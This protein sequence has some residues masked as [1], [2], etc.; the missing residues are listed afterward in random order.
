MAKKEAEQ[1]KIVARADAEKAKQDALTAIEQGKAVV[2]KAQAE[3]NEK[4]IRQVVKAQADF[5]AAQ[6]QKKQAQEV[7]QAKVLEGEA[8]ARVARLKVSAGLTPLERAEIDMKTK[9]GIAE[10]LAKANFPSVLINGG[11]GNGKGGNLSPI[12][13]LGY[14]SMYNLTKRIADERPRAPRPAA[15]A[16]APATEEEEK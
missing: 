16:A 6:F 14:E 12:D 4:K 2:A 8:E 15:P 3:E 1:K 13:A 7:A 11:S 10:A 9:I 5:E